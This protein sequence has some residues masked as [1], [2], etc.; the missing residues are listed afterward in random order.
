MRLPISYLVNN[1]NLH[2]ISHCLPNI[3]QYRIDQIIALD[4]RCLS[5]T[6][7]FSETSKNIA[8][9]HC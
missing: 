9:S 7:S 8:L 2:P 5:V 4:M 1:T 3:V 6:N